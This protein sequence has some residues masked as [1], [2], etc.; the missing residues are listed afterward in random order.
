MTRVF[1]AG[2]FHETHSFSGDTTMLEKEW[3]SWKMPATNTLVMY[4]TTNPRSSFC[5]FNDDCKTCR[6]APLAWALFAVTMAA[7][8]N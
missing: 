4:A 5:G 6:G 1:V 2:I 7:A 3:V 8:G